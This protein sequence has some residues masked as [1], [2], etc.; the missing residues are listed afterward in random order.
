[1]THVPFAAPSIGED[2]I[3]AV[4]EILRSGWIGT[5]AVAADTE[6]D[7]RKYL[8]VEHCLLLNSGTAALHLALA[9]LGVTAGD[10]VI[11]PTVTFTATAATVVHVKAHPVLVDVE[12]ETLT[13]DVA[14]VRQA[15]TARTRA[16]IAVHF[17]GRLADMVALR[18]LCDT[19]GLLL[20]EDSAHALPAQRDGVAPG[21]VS[22][23]AAFSFFV[24]KPL[25]SAE[26][27]LLTLR[28][29]RAA[30]TARM[31][32]TH[33]I[34]R[35]AYSRFEFGRSPHYD[36]VTPG[37]KYNLPDFAAA[38]LRIQLG[39]ATALRD[40]RRRTAEFYST[41]LAGVPGLI[42][43]APDTDDNASSWYLYVVH[44]P[45]GVDRDAVA[46]LMHAR[47]VGTSV[48]LRPLHQFSAYRNLPGAR[49]LG[50][51]PVA[52]AAFPR[53]LSLPIFPAMTEDDRRT[54]ARTF[55]AVLAEVRG[56]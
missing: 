9:S 30:A 18:S 33:G 8:G 16:V 1:V 52:D 29:S 24:T 41:Q 55:L 17:A 32:S 11:V 13:I 39:R 42:L 7:F 3:A 5:G 43:P 10:E 51:Y 48:H 21:Q 14:A 44:L 54:V 31:L 2:E 28:D 12:A 4:T 23:A 47:G 34:D 37:F 36:V 40:H 26:G 45:E 6:Q 19:H 49:G 20:I 53:L 35:G 56:G 38:L 46:A 27:G 22:D 50:G 15:I 25:T